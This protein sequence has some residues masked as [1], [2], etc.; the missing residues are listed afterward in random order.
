MLAVLAAGRD[1]ALLRAGLEGAG[2]HVLDLDGRARRDV[3]VEDVHGQAERGTCVGDVDYAR[4][5][6][7]DRCA[8]EEQIDLIVRVPE[9]AEVLDGP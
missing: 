5:M 1:L 7:L 2:A 9:A 8:G 3:E 6:P 4:H